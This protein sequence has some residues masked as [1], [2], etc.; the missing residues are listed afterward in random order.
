[1]NYGNFFRLD[2]EKSNLSCGITCYDYIWLRDNEDSKG[3]AEFPIY[4]TIGKDSIDFHSHYHDYN[5]DCDYIHKHLHNTI[6][7]LPLSANIEIKDGLTGALIEGWRT[8]YPRYEEY[9]LDKEEGNNYLYKKIKYAIQNNKNDGFSYAGLP[10]FNELSQKRN[11]IEDAKRKIQKKEKNGEHYDFSKFI[12]KLILDF[13]FDLEHTKVFQTSPHYE[14]ISVKL[15]EN[16]FFSALAAK[17]NFYYWREVLIQ[18]KK[19]RRKE[20][21]LSVYVEYYLNA[22]REWTKSIRSPKAPTNFNDFKDRW[23]EDPE[24]EMDRVYGKE[25][26]YISDLVKTQKE[27]IEKSRKKTSEW[28]TWHYAWDWKLWWGKKDFLGWHLLFPRLM[29]SV[30]TAWVTIII[31]S[32]LLPAMLSKDDLDANIKTSK[33]SFFEISKIDTIENLKDLK[34]FVGINKLESVKEE[35]CCFEVL[36]T[37][38]IQYVVIKGEPIE[39]NASDGAFFRIANIDDSRIWIFIG[40]VI[41]VIHILTCYSI[42]SKRKNNKYKG[43]LKYIWFIIVR[44]FKIT[45]ISFIFSVS[46][47]SFL[48]SMFSTSVPIKWNLLTYLQN[49]FF[50]SCVFL[51]MLIGIVLRLATDEKYTEE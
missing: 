4:V 22:E 10:I 49:P 25:F 46:F 18:E 47:G 29:A 50:I 27:G 31:G 3:S 5:K 1:M 43:S 9:P 51:A 11:I 7:S 48:A 39:L 12:R 6:L 38:E 20:K 14:H 2:N 28:L 37:D 24:V 19:N 23:F 17:A 8:N 40:F 45:V 32:D 34:N 42:I 41:F 36:E 26:D 16:Y 30:L 15:K 13:L 21:T 44:P 35:K 33:G